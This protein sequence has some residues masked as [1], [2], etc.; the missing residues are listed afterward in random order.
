MDSSFRT[1][2][3]ITPDGAVVWH[4][5]MVIAKC[6]TNTQFNPSTNKCDTIT[7]TIGNG[8]GTT[9]IENNTHSTNTTKIPPITA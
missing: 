4:D 3:G 2:F 8:T 7:A 5:G 6:P 9:I 1:A